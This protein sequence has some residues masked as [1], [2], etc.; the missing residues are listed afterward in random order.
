MR[1]CVPP[2]LLTD[3]YQLAMAASYLA[4][5]R[6][7]DRVAF[8]LFVRELPEHRG[9]LLTAGLET[10]LRY[11]EHLHFGPDSLEYLE[12]SQTCE[13]PL[14]DVLAGVRFEGDIDAMP[15]GTVA[16]ANEP[17]LRVEGPRLV[18]Q[19]AE[20]FLLN[21]VN[22]QTLIA[23]KAARIVQAAAGRPVVDFGFRRAHGGEAGVLAARSAYI[24]GVIATATVA[25]GYEWGIP[26]TGTMSHSYVMGFPSELDAY[27]AFL[28]DQPVRPTLLID[29]YET[30]EGARLAAEAARLTGVAPTAV[31]LDSG[32]VDEL[33]REVRSVLDEAGLDATGIF[34]SGDLDEYRI[35]ELVERGAP[36]DGFGAGTRLVTGG[37]V[38]ALGGV[39]KLVESAGRPV[40]KRSSRKAT[41][42]GRHQVFRS[43]GGDVVGLAGEQLEGTP[44]LQPVMRDGR[45]VG[46]TSALEDIRGRARRELAAQPERVRA[47]RDPATVRP[48]LSAAVEALR[49]E[50][51]HA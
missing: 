31:R 45:R 37:D 8:E 10:A 24:G 11:L 9:Y 51:T 27:C 21:L 25:A 34:C 44:L 22:F 19:L 23:T 36:I 17:L 46:D 20:S 6:A 1:A 5:G 40:M 38:S 49:G 32:D 15:E 26:T 16:F 42:P 48:S 4:Q 43:A 18:C 35:A 39:Y 47:L 7:D 28:R 3:R 14:L 50:L 33:S 41:L 2:E 29:T 12:R 13:R 30:V